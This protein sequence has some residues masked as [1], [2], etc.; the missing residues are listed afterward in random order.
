MSGNKGVYRARRRD[1]EACA[2]GRTHHVDSVAYGAADGMVSRECSDG[3]PAAWKE[4]DGTLWFATI[5]GVAAVDPAR[6]DPPPPRPAIEAATVDHAPRAVSRAL[7]LRPG[8]ADLEIQY[9]AFNW[10][11]P[12]RVR[13]QY[14]LAGLDQE[15]KDAGTRRTAYFS[16][17]PPGNYAFWVRADGGDGAWSEAVSLPVIVWPPFWR[18]G[19][20]LALAAGLAGGAGEQR[21]SLA[22]PATPTPLRA[23]SRSSPRRLIAAHETERRRIAAE[24]HDS[25]GQ[26]LAMIKNSAVSGTRHARDLAAAQAQMEQ[27]TQQSTY[28]IGEV[29]EIAYNL[30]PYLLDRLGLTKALRSM[31][32]K[33]GDSSGLV[34]TAELDNIDGCFPSE[35]EMSIYRIVQESFNNVLKHADAKHVLVRLQARA[36]HDG[37]DDPRRRQGLRSSRVQPRGATWLRPARDRRARASARRYLCV[38]IQAGRGHDGFHP[39]AAAGS[40]EHHPLTCPHP[41]AS[42][43]PTIIPSSATGY[44]RSSRPMTP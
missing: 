17:L 26:T 21:F 23:S 13:F 20:F 24:L 2:D 32:H 10:Q 16:H 14:Q 22:R 19:W 37:F 44:A 35:A 9:T 8:Q 25:L 18:T 36:S 29:R 41:S 34:I 28:A 27:I 42:S 39:P 1:L 43:W 11:Q 40:S 33:I 3:S 38:A 12:E 7:E 15:W 6:R 31:L 5:G 30:R 4:R